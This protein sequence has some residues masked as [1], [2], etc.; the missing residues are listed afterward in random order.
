MIESIIIRALEEYD[1]GRLP[2]TCIAQTSIDSFTLTFQR[3]D[4]GVQTRIILFVEN[5]KLH[6]TTEW[7]H[8]GYE[9]E[10]YRDYVQTIVCDTSSIRNAISARIGNNQKELIV[11]ILDNVLNGWEWPDA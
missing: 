8:E 4:P 2:N 7:W 9:R 3:P 10:P 1:A 11:S 5:D 6:L